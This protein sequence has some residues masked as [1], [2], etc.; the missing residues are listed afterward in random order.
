MAK[1]HVSLSGL[2]FECVLIFW[3]ENT[4]NKNNNKI[5][6]KKLNKSENSLEFKILHK[7][8]QNFNNRMEKDWKKVGGKN[9]Q[10]TCSINENLNV[11]VSLLLVLRPL[12]LVETIFIHKCC[13]MFSVLFGCSESEKGSLDDVF[14]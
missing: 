7:T 3:L 8:V 12:V 1:M 6:K 4:Q 9:T 13:C 14:I 2:L 10:N 5:K 11:F